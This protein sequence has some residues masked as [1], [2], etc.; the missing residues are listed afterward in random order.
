LAHPDE[1][2][3]AILSIDDNH[4][5]ARKNSVDLDEI[6]VTGSTAVERVAYDPKRGRLYVTYEGGKSYYYRRVQP[7]TVLELHKAET[8]G[9]VINEIKKS[10][11]YVP[12]P[13][14]PEKIDTKSLDD[15]DIASQIQ[16]N[17]IPTLTAIDKSEVG[18]PMRIVVP[19]DT[20]ASGG[21][22]VRINGIT[23]ARIY[24]DEMSVGD[25]ELVV[26]IPADAR[27]IPF[28]AS[29]FDK[30]KTGSKTMMMVP[31]MRVAVLD[32]KN[33]RRGEM[34]HQDSAD[35][36]LERIIEDWPIGRDAKDGKIMSMSKRKAEEVIASHL[37]M[38]E[39]KNEL[40]DGSTAPIAT[41]RIRTRNADIH[42]RQT[43]RGSSP[44]KPTS[45]YR[46]TVSTQG[47]GSM[48]RIE[49]QEERNFGRM[50]AHSNIVSA[51]RTDASIDPE[52]QRLI[53]GMDD[54]DISQMIDY[55]AIEFHEGVDRK[56]R[57]RV[58]ND[59][60]EKIISDGGRYYKNEDH[61]S[62]MEKKYQALIGIHPDTDEIDRPV[63]G[64]VV[65]PAQDLAARN[66]MRRRGVQV[67]DGP[68]EWPNES[69]P[70]GDIG[71]DG[72]IEV[73]LKPE[74]S[75]RTA[76][77]FGYG[78]DEKTRPVWLNSSDHA[79]I[80]DA[81]VHVDPATDPDGSRTRVLNSLS[82]VVDGDFGY[83][84]DTGSVKP[85]ATSQNERTEEFG[86]RVASH[87]KASKPQRLGAQIMGGFVNE[88][89]SEVRYPWS[90]VSSSSS[91]VDISDVVNKEPVSDRLRR[92]G[93]TDA[94][95]E[96][97]YKV[98][99]NR[100]LDYISSSTMASLKEYR[101]ALEIKKDYE[102]RGIP[103]VSFMHPAGLDPL[104][105]SSYSDRPVGKTT[106]ESAL[107]Q[108]INA[109]V[110]EMLEKMLKQVRKTRGKIW[111]MKPKVGA[112]T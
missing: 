55:V 21:E 89:I 32:D 98:N 23:S 13:R 82:A 112:L 39:G 81:I 105:V 91:D 65:H 44:T 5:K 41:R 64:Y 15:A 16:F 1:I 104:D 48:G 90:K 57:L 30:S 78:I 20:S 4:K 6:D 88:E 84:T 71:A 63:L 18:T 70:H 86:K 40:A 108:A 97:F 95:I 8:K 31:P 50:S 17:L 12:V 11:D 60:L 111:E 67:G 28:E 62:T 76:Y 53:G 74:V 38:G 58:S 87:R 56:P 34:I 42:A 72:D 46:N 49:T 2:S 45:T 99:G 94:E 77:G 7:E 19:V 61:F 52:I 103:N 79:A 85:A 100:S 22:S 43:K 54:R 102:K 29:V 106:I 37:A 109:Q 3:L 36:T 24:H 47:L 110:D 101:K 25:N 96:Y 9:K 66:E 73:V 51:V 68:I 69:N 107:A 93:F 59:E 10:H 27:G 80:S 75:G 92:L 26:T 83:L 33:G 35:T 14:I